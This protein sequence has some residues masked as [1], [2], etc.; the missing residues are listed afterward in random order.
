MSQSTCDLFQNE[1][2]LELADLVAFACLYLSDKQVLV[3]FTAQL[4]FCIYWSFRLSYTVFIQIF[5]SPRDGSIDR[6][7]QS[8]KN[9]QQVQ[10][11]MQIHAHK[12]NKNAT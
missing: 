7:R 12:K 11:Q 6:N 10:K 3:Q 4:I 8:T 1:S 5:Y 2:H 9:M